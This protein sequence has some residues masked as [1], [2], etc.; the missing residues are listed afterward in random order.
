M[1]DPP[2]DGDAVRCL[3]DFAGD[4]N[5]PALS[6]GESLTVV[7]KHDS[8]W[9]EITTSGGLS[10][11]ISPAWVAPIDSVSEGAEMEVASSTATG[12]EEWQP[13]DMPFTAGALRGSIGPADQSRPSAGRLSDIAQAVSEEGELSPSPRGSLAPPPPKRTSSQLVMMP[14]GDAT[15]KNAKPPVAVRKASKVAEGMSAEFLGDLSTKVSV[16]GAAA[17]APKATGADSSDPMMESKRVPP[18]VAAK[19][20]SSLASVPPTPPTRSSKPSLL[21]DFG[22]PLAV[23]ADNDDAAIPGRPG[24]GTPFPKQGDFRPAF[25]GVD[26]A[27]LPPMPESSPNVAGAVPPSAPST[28]APPPLPAAVPPPL[29]TTTPPPPPSGGAMAAPA[30]AAMDQSS[31]QSKLARRNSYKPFESQLERKVLVEGGHEVKSRKWEKCYAALAGPTLYFFKDEKAKR[32]GKRPVGFMFMKGKTYVDEPDVPK[33][34]NTF[35]L[36]D[37]VEKYLLC[38]PSVDI[39]SGWATRFDRSQSAESLPIPEDRPGADTTAAVGADDTEHDDVPEE[40]SAGVGPAVVAV[41]GEDIEKYCDVR[42][43]LKRLLS[44][45][46]GPSDVAALGEVSDAV[47]CG[48]VTEQVVREELSRPDTAYPGVPTIVVRC[49][50]IVDK[51]LKETGI[52]RISGNSGKVQALKKACDADIFTAPISDADEVHTVS[53][54]FKL[55]FRELEDPLFTDTLYDQFMVAAREHDLEVRNR[56]VRKLVH[57]LPLAHQATLE[58]VCRHLLRVAAHEEANMMGIQN[59]AIVFGPTLLR[60]STSSPQ[61]ILTDSSYQSAV[62]EQILSNL[63]WFLTDEDVL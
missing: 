41:T 24:Y 44:Q 40:T 38:A 11:F 34:K 3:Y 59:V 20:R 51:H 28:T 50:E 5:T 17:A 49:V 36:G 33:K 8:G 39:K 60:C 62:I 57:A 52:Y 1:A 18:P 9:L 4:A 29:P 27:T 25:V 37:S 30:P 12:K 55:Y 45:R 56:S 6:K 7:Q 46:P 19:P 54:L 22:T 13:V 43:T 47:F 35:S 61:A 58:F 16:E 2:R 26:P 10:G 14:S 53:G 42:C 15:T 32:A 23:A 48:H 63:D 21:E 31:G